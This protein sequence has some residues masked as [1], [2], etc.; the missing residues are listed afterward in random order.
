MNPKQ[1]EQLIKDGLQRFYERRT[2]SLSTL[3][4]ADLLRRKNPY[5]LKAL[6][7]ENVFDLVAE[8]L[9]QHIIA[10]D[11]TIFGDA[12]VEPIALAISGAK[13]SSAK[14]ID[15]EIE[16]DTTYKAVSVK[17]GPNVF[18]SSQVDQ[19]NRQFEELRKRLDAY[20]RTMGKHFDPVLGAAYGRRNSPPSEKRRYRLLA[21]QAF[22]YELTGDPEFHV[23]LIQL[24]KNYPQQ[25]RH[26]FEAEWNRAANRLAKYLLT[27]FTTPAGDIDWEKLLK[28]NSGEAIFSEEN[29]PE[30]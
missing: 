23:R 5:L 18:N 24:M 26:V 27:E 7:L 8:L 30:Q 20:L 3:R 21:G 6:G 29:S 28:F 17:S 14:G 1:L 11:E 15:L 13:K 12:F 10:S 4:P 22:W 16:T 19:M 2:A 9:R 25:Y